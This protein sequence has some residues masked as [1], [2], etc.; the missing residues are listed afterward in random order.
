MDVRGNVIAS[1][2]PESDKRYED[3]LIHRIDMGDLWAWCV[4]E[5]RAEFRGIIASTYL[6]GC[7]YE[8]SDDFM[9]CP[10][11]KDMVADVVR[12]LAYEIT[13]LQGIEINQNMGAPTDVPIIEGP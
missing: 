13:D 9:R 10:Y 7:S 2:D 1:D 12:R 3:N 6:G 5:V 11:Y 8:N 4:I